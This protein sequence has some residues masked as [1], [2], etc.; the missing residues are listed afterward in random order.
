MINIV[1]LNF[2]LT[3]IKFDFTKYPSVEK[4]INSLLLVAIIWVFFVLAEYIIDQIVVVFVKKTKPVRK[5]LINFFIKVFKVF[6][7]VVGIGM[8]AKK[9]DYDI[10]VLMT[11]MGLGGLAFALAAKGVLE[12][13]F[14][15]LL[16]LTNNPFEYGDSIDTGSVEGT[17]VEVNLITTIV[18]TFDNALITIPNSTIV[19]SNIKNWSRRRM[20]RRIKMF[21]GVEYST[22]KKSLE[23]VIEEI[24]EMLKNHPDIATNL[25]S[26]QIVGLD[27]I[28]NKNDK[29][30]VKDSLL[31]CLDN[32]GD[33]SI[34]ILVYTFTKT[35]NW[36][37]WLLVKQDIMLKIIDILEK[38]QV[39]IAFPSSTLYVENKGERR[40]F[41]A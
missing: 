6:V 12:N 1:G 34:N 40:L 10:S 17:V 23:L 13:F 24:Q 22:P 11:T 41:N 33:S 32:F 25:Q 14:A 37:E 29:E 8:F 20:G 39:N 21:V 5:S 27:D 9:W 16:I 36:D 19:N 28:L 35:V 2:A 15:G 4:S 7:V 18:R 30:G 31:V 38:H 26:S 3:V